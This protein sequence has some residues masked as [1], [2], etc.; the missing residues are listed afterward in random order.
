MELEEDFIQWLRSE[1]AA[2]STL[3]YW[4]S[5]FREFAKYCRTERIEFIDLN[6]AISRKYMIFLLERPNYQTGGS[7]SSA[8]RAKHYDFLTSFSRFLNE[9]GIINCNLTEGIKRPKPRYKVINSLSQEQ[10]HAILQTVKEVRSTK[11]AQERTALLI[12]LIASTGLRVGEALPLRPSEFDFHRRIITV[13]GKGDREREVPFG[14]ELSYLI[15]KYIE[16]NGMKLDSYLWAT[17][18]GKPMTQSSF[19]GTL[20]TIKKYIGTSLGIDRIRLSPHTFRHTFAKMWVV[21]GG[22]T[23]ALSRI[24]GHSSTSMTDKYVKLWG[25]DMS[26]A[27]DI[28]NP[29]EGLRMPTF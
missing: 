8:T 10:L 29:C 20:T 14:F 18:T 9:H 17:Y 4:S 11:K 28:C 19:R 21:K 24:L 22:N 23:I 15:Q 25:I 5:R 7:L 16:E 3:P 6:V 26:S 1:N 12:Y 27:Y 2:T 13:N